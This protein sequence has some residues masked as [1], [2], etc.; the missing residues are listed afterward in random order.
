[1]QLREWVTLSSFEQQYRKP[2]SCYP[3]SIFRGKRPSIRFYNPSKRTTFYMIPAW[4][5]NI[6][7]LW[8]HRWGVERVSERRL[9]GKTNSHRTHWASQGTVGPAPAAIQNGGIGQGNLVQA[10]WLVGGKKWK[11]ERENTKKIKKQ[12]TG[13]KDQRGEV[14]ADRNRSWTIRSWGSSVHLIL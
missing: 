5:F 4:A 2:N 10:L 6:Y 8:A 11:Q 14:R 13:L 1:M 12:R 7:P 3:T 9:R